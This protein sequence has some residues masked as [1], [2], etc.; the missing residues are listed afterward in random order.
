VVSLRSA[1]TGLDAGSISGFIGGE[2]RNIEKCDEAIGESHG[3]PAA[4]EVLGKQKDELAA[5]VSEMKA[6]HRNAK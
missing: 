6:W 5:L 1:V 3:H 2:T 4:V